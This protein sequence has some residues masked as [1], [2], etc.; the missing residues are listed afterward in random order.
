MYNKVQKAWRHKLERLKVKSRVLHGSKLEKIKTDIDYME[1]TDM[2]VVVSGGQNEY[3]RLRAKGLDLKVHRER[4]L[5]EK[6]DDK[7]RDPDDPLNIVFVCA[8]WLTGFDAPFTSTLYLDKPLKNHTL[9]QTIARANRVYPGKPNGQVVDY[10]NIFG[11]LQEALGR[12]GSVNE[13]DGS[14]Y[15]ETDT[16]AKD[17]TVQFHALQDA[18]NDVSKY[19]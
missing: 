16:P 14:T 4:M 10:I 6:L 9:M 13:D 5:K 8:M 15:G 12:Y 19:L 7:F 1:K 17:K 2:A 3:E 11:A 18:L